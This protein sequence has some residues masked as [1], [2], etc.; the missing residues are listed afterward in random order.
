VNWRTIETI[1]EIIFASAQKTF[2]YRL[3]FKIALWAKSF[4]IG[5]AE[6]VNSVQ[7][8]FKNAFNMLF[9]QYALG[10]FLDLWGEW[11]GIDRNLGSK[12]SGSINAC[13]DITG[14]N[15]PYGTLFQSTDGFIYELTE[16]VTTAKV[17]ST[18][19]SFSITN[20][21]AYA[22][23]A[24][25]HEYATG[26]EVVLVL[27]ELG[28]ITSSAIVVT[29]TNSFQFS[30]D[31]NNLTSDT[32]TTHDFFALATIQSVEIGLNQ[33]IDSGNLQ[34]IDTISDTRDSSY[35]KE[36][37][38]SGADVEQDGPYRTRILN[39]R[40]QMKGVFTFDNVQ[41]AG[42]RVSG[43]DSIINDPPITGAEDPVKIAGY[44]PRAGET[45]VYVVRRDSTGNIVT[46]VAQTILDETK[47]KII[48]FGK[49]PAN[50]V[51]SDVHAFSPLLQVIDMS[52]S[53]LPDTTSMRTA[54]G[55]SI[56]AFFYDN[57]RFD[58]TIS[59][60][61]IDVAISKTYDYVAGIKLDD[62]NIISPTSITP[63][64]KHIPIKG[65]VTYV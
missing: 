24:T 39:S 37:I 6:A 43:N 18:L 28:T 36:K 44:Q 51:E 27:S 31:E 53:I 23:T 9:P 50:T 13:S 29:D 35:I 15:F 4:M 21:I 42:L 52:L 10:E 47:A 14:I 55:T 45:V 7:T 33:N 5:T 25:E 46:P 63:I 48:E 57:E 62:F 20:G 64:A 16:D 12:A 17:E 3:D 22:V 32:G 11:E 34:L 49:L 65:V 54:V 60:Q 58:T 26:Q 8:V 2:D 30:I 56:D 61:D 41:L 38:A 59:V 1:K 19:S 40:R